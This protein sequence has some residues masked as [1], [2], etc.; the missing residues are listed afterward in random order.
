MSQVEKAI[1]S[2]YGDQIESLYMVFSQA[3]LLAN[4]DAE[5]VAAAEKRFKAGLAHAADV[6]TRARAAAEL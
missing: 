4:N 2:A 6:H 3:I 5:E 1:E